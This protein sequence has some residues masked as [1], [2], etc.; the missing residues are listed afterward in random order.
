MSLDIDLVG[1][2]GRPFEHTYTWK[3]C[4]LYALGVGARVP[5]EL[6]FLYEQRGPKVLPTFAVTVPFL[7]MLDLC[8]K[9]GADLSRLLHGEQNLIQHR[10]IPSGGT[11]ITT[12]TVTGIYDKGKGALVVIAARSTDGHGEPLFDNE[13]SLFVRGAGGFGGDRG[14]AP[15][16]AEPPA[17]RLPDFTVTETTSPEQAALYRLSG[18]LNPLHIAPELARLAG[19]DRPILHGL[20]TYGHAG[21]AIL[22]GACGGD[23]ARFRSF[24]ARFSGVVFPGDTLTTHGWK[25]DAGTYVIQVTKADGTV[26]LSHAMAE[27][28]PSPRST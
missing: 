4:V 17:D 13:Y 1:K 3:D 28:I 14:P 9:L 12:A 5:S 10:P 24:A 11:L 19:F 22:Q 16:H 18:D 7:A 15:R 23:P 21:R 8:A 27:V 20:C 25:R 2:A 6:D 26:V